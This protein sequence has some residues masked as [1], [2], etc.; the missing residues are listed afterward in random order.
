MGVSHDCERQQAESW[1]V[2]WTSTP[3]REMVECN[4]VRQTQTLLPIDPPSPDPS[5]PSP[6]YSVAKYHTTHPIPYFAFLCSTVTWPTQ[7][8]TS[9]AS[10][11]LSYDPPG[12]H[13][14]TQWST[15]T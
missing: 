3:H 12:S 15:V 7:F 8:P 11:Q 14:A 6:C 1:I 13:F 5:S 10:G 2:C 9:L 4:Q